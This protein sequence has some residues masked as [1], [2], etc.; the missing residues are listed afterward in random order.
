MPNLA[1]LGFSILASLPLSAIG[2]PR[3]DGR[4]P[5]H[6]LPGKCVFRVSALPNPAAPAGSTGSVTVGTESDC[7]WTASSDSTWFSITAGASGTGSGTV[8]YTIAANTGPSQRTATV[9]IAGHGFTLTQ[10]S[11]TAACGFSLDGTLIDLPFNGG[12]GTIKVT[13]SAQSCQWSAASNAPWLFIVSGTSGTGNGVTVFSAGS[14]PSVTARKG[15]LT[16]AGLAFTVAQAGVPGAVSLSAPGSPVAASGGS[17]TVDVVATAQDFAWTATAGVAWLTITSNPNGRGDGTV[18]WSA[19]ANASNSSRTG[20]LNIG[21][22]IFAVYQ[23]SSTPGP[24]L[25]VTNVS[26][27]FSA[28]TDGV[29]IVD[30]GT[31]KVLGYAATPG[32]FTHGVTFTP[33]GT[34]AWAAADFGEQVVAIDSQTLRVLANIPVPGNPRNV[35]FL[36]DGSKAYAVTESGTVAIINPANHK[37]LSTLDVSTTLPLYDQYPPYYM[38]AVVSPDGGTAYLADVGG[39]ITILNTQTDHVIAR[40]TPGTP[41]S[42]TFQWIAL[43]PDGTKAYITDSKLAQLFVLDTRTYQVVAA[44]NVPGVERGVAISPDGNKAYIADEAGFVQVLDLKTYKVLASIGVANGGARGI[45]VSADGS[46]VYATEPEDVAV[47]STAANAVVETIPLNGCCAV[48]LGIQQPRP[49]LRLSA[50]VQSVAS[51]SGSGTFQVIAL[52]P[53]LNWTATSEAAWLTV[54]G[55]ASGVGNGTV[56]FTIAANPSGAQRIGAI[57]VGNAVFSVVQSGQ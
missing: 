6:P 2:Q 42:D 41:G 36:P 57:A 49:P 46:L 10:D 11:A 37:V 1:R 4:P 28:T 43:S 16:V 22:E 32:G 51:S 38:A 48:Q 44:V 55:G 12:P 34:Q 9:T 27:S 23:P 50:G 17:G 52:S 20:T 24:L 47:I 30:T 18:T 8:A 13:A 54:T 3:E 29:A 25:V 26:P 56:S 31:S 39:T 40:L 19:A 33:D 45:T 21:G 35:T 7:S 15:S 14:N 5:V 53:S